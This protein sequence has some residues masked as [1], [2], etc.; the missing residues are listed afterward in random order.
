VIVAPRFYADR[1][2][3]GSIAMEDVPPERLAPWLRRLAARSGLAR[4]IALGLLARRGTRV[5]VIRRA[6][7]SP[8]A[9]LVAGL[10][11]ALR[12]GVAAAQV[13]TA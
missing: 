12:R 4:G 5:A 11:P 8:P 13:M 6:R 1:L 2:G 9:L 7:G 10:P 3:E